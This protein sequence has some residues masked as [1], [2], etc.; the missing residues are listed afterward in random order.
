MKDK[1][2]RLS[3]PGKVYDLLWSDDEF[4]RDVTGHKKVSSAGAFPKVDQWC[5]EEGF[6]MAFALAGYSPDNVRLETCA[7]E[8][9]VTGT[10]NKIEQDSELQSQSDDED[11]YPAKTPNLR[12]Q[13]GII[14]RG[15]ARR[16]F[17]T[18][19]FINY[20]FDLSRVHASM[21]NGLLEILIPKRDDVKLVEVKI[22][23]EHE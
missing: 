7:N 4:Y 11:E 23:S 2:I 15:I 3:I 5:D 17:K 12:V 18:K 16:N 6:H 10:R 14:V 13:Q 20:N 19:Y 8:L 9:I 22:R 1:V 21:E